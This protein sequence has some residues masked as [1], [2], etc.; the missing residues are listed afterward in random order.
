MNSM[1]TSQEDHLEPITPLELVKLIRRLKSKKSAGYDHI[2][3]HMIKRLPPTYV[4]CLTICYIK[5]LQEHRYPDCWK[6]TKIVTIN[7]L[8]A[9]TPRSDQ[10]RP[11]S[12]LP[13]HS[14][15]F[16]KVMIEKVRVWAEERQLVPQ[17]Q[18]G[19]RPG[20]LLPTRVLSIYQ[21][22]KNNIAANMPTLAIYVD[23]KKA[24]DLVWHAGLLV[25]LW[26]PRNARRTTK[27]HHI[28][29]K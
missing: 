23:Y 18:S 28:V 19:F 6:V 26:G 1:A 25:K 24:F 5:W 9:G 29:A 16:G 8:K 13:T 12:L 4:Q 3:K 15:L 21:E 20:G 10:T 7:K 11:I 14:K 22:V 17:E 27:D 2:S